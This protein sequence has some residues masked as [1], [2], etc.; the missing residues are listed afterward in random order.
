MT[1]RGEWNIACS[2]GS[3]NFFRGDH[4]D[5]ALFFMVCGDCDAVYGCGKALWE[6][7]P[8]RTAA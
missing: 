4:V 5:D 8:E 2:Y 7:L 3:H 1:E 6:A